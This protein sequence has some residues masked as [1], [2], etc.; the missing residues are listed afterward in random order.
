[1]ANAIQVANGGWPD[2][3]GFR[4]ELNSTAA[5]VAAYQA[6]RNTFRAAGY[7][8]LVVFGSFGVGRPDWTEWAPL[9]SAF[10][11]N[12]PDAIELHEYFSL[13]VGFSHSQM[14]ALRHVTLYQQNAIPASWPCFIGECG[15]DDVGVKNVYED[16]QRRRGWNDHGKLTA[17]A[18]AAQLALYAQGC[19]PQIV[20]AFVYVDGS[21]GDPQWAS[22]TTRGH[23]EIELAEAATQPAIPAPPPVQER[24]TMVRLGVRVVNQLETDAAGALDQ[25][26]YDNCG[27]ATGLAIALTL[28]DA[29][30]TETIPQFLSEETGSPDWQGYTYT[31][32]MAAW[33]VNRG[34]DAVQSQPVDLP[35]ALQQIVD[36][37]YFAALLRY[38]DETALT[39]GHFEAVDGYAVDAN[40]VRTWTVM[41]PYGGTWE[42][43]SDDDLN[44]LSIGHWIV[45]VR[46]RKPVPMPTEDPAITFARNLARE[47]NPAIRFNEQGALFTS[48]VR[49]TS[50]YRQSGDASL[51]PGYWVYDETVIPDGSEAF[52]LLSSGIVG[53]WVRSVGYTRVAERPK[54]DEMIRQKTGWKL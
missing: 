14:L 26:A 16:T 23:Q 21:N 25:N 46:E 30:N 51:N 35:A 40:G 13:T 24:S 29:P 11:S 28:E 2:A 15:S 36:Q 49:M 5:N 42:T 39:G 53:H 8:G 10:W 43:F 33:F 41:N 48:Y 38:W 27:P 7:T 44:R 50:A 34:H 52:M 32:Q 12:P 1:V 6:Y 19:A 45:V 31:N 17:A 20:A 22:Y 4:N 18:Y 54:E 9:V 37:G 3:I 47:A